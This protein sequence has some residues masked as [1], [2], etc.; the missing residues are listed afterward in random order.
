MGRCKKSYGG[1]HED[2]T[3]YWVLFGPLGGGGVPPLGGGVPPLGLYYYRLQRGR[4]P[5]WAGWAPRS[6]IPPPG[7]PA[8]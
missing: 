6:I 8:L 5:P 3:S 1:R 7:A 4:T 2:A